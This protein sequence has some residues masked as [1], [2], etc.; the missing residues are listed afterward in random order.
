MK[1]FVKTFIVVVFVVSVL[2]SCRTQHFVNK[3]VSDKITR[4][5]ELVG[6][7]EEQAVKLKRAETNYV[8]HR[9]QTCGNDEEQQKLEVKKKIWLQNILGYE[10]ALK[11]LE[12]EE[13]NCSQQKVTVG[14]YTRN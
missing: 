13:Q 6:F 5:Q 3:Y 10:K 2:S 1:R 4:M 12:I 11:Y 14:K 7:S 8:K 9:I